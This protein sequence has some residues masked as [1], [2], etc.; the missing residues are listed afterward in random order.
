[1]SLGEDSRPPVPVYN[2][3]GN[4]SMVRLDKASCYITHGHPEVKKSYTNADIRKGKLDQPCFKL[5]GLM[6][7]LIRDRL[8]P[9]NRIQWKTRFV[10]YVN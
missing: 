7:K 5:A 6:P 9:S 3:N 8:L 1:M 4:V 2:L 10:K